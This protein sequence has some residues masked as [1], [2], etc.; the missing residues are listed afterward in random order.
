ML[1]LTRKPGERIF[2]NDNIIVTIIWSQAGLVRVG[3]EAPN[4]VSI[5]RE[6]LYNKIKTEGWNPDRRKINVK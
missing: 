3:V 5:H 2:I 4:D 6:E 1:I